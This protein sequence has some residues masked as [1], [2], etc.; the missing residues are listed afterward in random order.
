MK[1]FKQFIAE[2]TV[3]NGNYYKIVNQPVL[4]Y[5][6]LGRAETKLTVVDPSQPII[7]QIKHQYKN[8]RSGRVY[9]SCQL[10]SDPKNIIE[11]KNRHGFIYEGKYIYL[12]ARNHFQPLTPHELVSVQF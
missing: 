10:F 7:V 11:N 6:G 2:N 5:E 9:F 1:S 4:Y 8:E 3:V 12:T